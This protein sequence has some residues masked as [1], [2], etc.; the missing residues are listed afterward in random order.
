MDKQKTKR[1]I[2]DFDSKQL[3]IFAELIARSASTLEF[4]TKLD[5]SPGDIEIQKNRT[6]IDSVQLA[7]D[8]LRALEPNEQDIL[9]KD[10]ERLAMKKVDKIIRH[11]VI[12]DKLDID[13]PYDI[14]KMQK[15]L[16]AIQ[17]K[18]IKIS[19]SVVPFKLNGNK[20]IEQFKSDSRHGMNFLMNKYSATRSEIIQ[21]LMD[22]KMDVENIRP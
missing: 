21:T 15:K 8:F 10:A 2:I 9:K 12:N 7:K 5:L 13:K 19:K 1:M 6:G 11:E 14:Q 3:K 20:E 18:S 17:K 4:Q 16:T 22:C